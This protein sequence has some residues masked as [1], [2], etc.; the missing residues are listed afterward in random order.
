MKKKMICLVTAIVIGGI[1]IMFY[2]KPVTTAIHNTFWNT[3]AKQLD[4]EWENAGPYGRPGKDTI[5][6][7]ANGKYQI[8]KFDKEKILF[9]YD[10]N[11]SMRALLRKVT[12][13]KVVRKKLYVVSDEGYGIVDENGNSCTLF[14][15]VPTEEFINGYNIDDSGTK[16]PISRFV[17]DEHIKYLDSFDE[18]SD[19][20]RA[21]FDRMN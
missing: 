11:G 9:M 5:C 20:E 17:S 7:F 13:H 12:K 10:E 4:K 16:H 2:W 18:F 1:V 14:I 8:G 15:T 19:E 3:I 21:V 6:W